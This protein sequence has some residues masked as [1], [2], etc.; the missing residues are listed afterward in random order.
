M[1]RRE[2]EKKCV[3]KMVNL[4]FIIWF[5]MEFI[6]FSL[7]FSPLSFLLLLTKHVMSSLFSPCM[8]N[9]IFP[10]FVES[11]SPL[12]MCWDVLCFYLVLIHSLKF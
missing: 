2:A 9:I 1:K 8:F 12:C 3:K 5:D 10:I 4:N 7:L 11:M 6:Y